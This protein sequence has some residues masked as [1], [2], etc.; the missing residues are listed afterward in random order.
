MDKLK[1][2]LIADD[3]PTNIKLLSD[4]LKREGYRIRVAVNG[5]QAVK[6]VEAELPDL[7]LMDVHMPK[8]NGYNAC[9][10][11]KA[12]KDGNMVP[13]IF[14]SAMAETFNKVLA[15]EAGAVDY[16]V[17]PFEMVEVL[18]RV[19]THISMYD[20]Q[21][22]LKD[23]NMDLFKKF[24]STFDQAAVGIVHAS[25]V[26]GKFLKVNGLFS[27]M[28]GY[29]QNEVMNM[30]IIDVLH[31]D[32]IE[33]EMS[34]IQGL[35]DN[36][37]SSYSHELLAKCKNQSY[38]WIRVTVSL[39]YD[40]LGKPDY[41]VGII[42]DISEQKLVEE[43]LKK[44]EKRLKEAQQ[45]AQLGN[46]E[47]DLK[48][49]QLYWSEE[50]F[51]IFEID[52]EKFEATYE[53][54]INIVHPDD[55]ERVNQ[56]YMNH[57]N[58]QQP[59][60]I[61]HRILLKDSTVKYVH[62]NGNIVF[63]EVGKAIISTGTVQDITEKKLAESEILKL[64]QELEERV[65]VRTRQLKQE[66]TFTDKVV[67][68]LPGIFYALDDE[69]RLKRWNDNYKNLVDIDA[70]KLEQI[71]LTETVAEADRENMESA[72]QNTFRD[73][74]AS[75][76]VCFMTQ[77]DQAVPYFITGSH[78]E[79]GDEDYYVGVGFDITK[80]KESEA[81]LRKLSRA[82]D[83]SP[84]SVVITDKDGRIQYVNKT[85]TEVTGYEIDDVLGKNPSVLQ[86]GITKR[87]V[88]AELWDTISE[89]L[90]WRGE[91]LNKK[92][93]G[94]IFWEAAS[95][96]PI[97]NEKGK[98]ISFVAVKED[99]TERKIMERELK[100]ARDKAESATVAKSEFLANM[101]HEIRTPMNAIIGM[102]HLA[103]KTKLSP[104]QRD[105]IT[106]ISIAGQNL[107]SIINEIL[108]FSKI[109]AGKLT[110]ENVEFD[111]NDVITNLSNIIVMKAQNK[112]LEVA[113][114]IDSTIGNHLIGDPLRLG[115][116]LLNLSNNAVKF[117]ESG[118]IIIR[119]E[120]IFNRYEIQRLKF[121]IVDTGIG[122]TAEQIGKLF[123]SFQQAD[124]S[125][126]RKYGGTGL[127]LVICKNIVEM[128]GGTIAVESEFHKGST[129]HF[130]I[131]FKIPIES[132][133]PEASGL[134]VPDILNKMPV[135]FDEI[136][137]ASILLVEDNE[138]NRQVAQEILEAEGFYINIAVNGQD[139]VDQMVHKQNHYD[140]ILMD[141]QMPVL[142]G[143]EATRII[144]EAMQIETVPIIAMTADAMAG[145]KKRIIEYGMND[146]VSKPFDVSNL[147]LTLIKWI[148][149]GKRVLPSTYANA[150]QEDVIEI[151]LPFVKLSG[152]DIKTGLVRT[153]SD[154]TLYLSLLRKFYQNNQ[155]TVED[156]K[157]A[158]QQQDYELA[159][160]IAHTTKSVAGLIGALRLNEISAKLE[161]E[162]S[163]HFGSTS[164]ELIV[165]FEECMIEILESLR[166]YSEIE[167]DVKT[168]SVIGTKE[169]LFKVLQELLPYSKSRSLTMSKK[170]IAELESKTW[171]ETYEE[172]V[173]GIV[174]NIKKYK[175]DIAKETI[176][177]I[178]NKMKSELNE[179][180]ESM[181]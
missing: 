32:Y 93:N 34:N 62:E 58:N 40:S 61:D 104:K 128:M 2:I 60:D 123:E 25:P 172:E 80:R 139:A 97:L 67:N 169:D 74:F 51:R 7:V 43:T 98:I 27:S 57:I 83:Q 88:Y 142:D 50:V 152:I 120:K 24:Q 145:T 13:V 81:E 161:R 159:G 125:T 54:F 31:P 56:A 176:E 77:S 150:I 29:S 11:I 103:L 106:K 143:Y 21:Q 165:Q 68:S 66:K 47:L 17:K 52:F 78:L 115:Q 65:G 110:L 166:L 45:L 138:I 5:E 108:D 14:V 170:Y 59:Y 179:S 35:L 162:I 30:K 26:D 136:R 49:N 175:F 144:R 71:K 86:S 180:D 149:P 72:I 73:G 9:R 155:K 37:Y 4:I 111:L 132:D 146:F 133:T 82:V 39:I 38:I 122:L 131:D 6:S 8:M 173:R 147:F 113:F 118:E 116:V 94:E 46:W 44:N 163:T 157:D 109:E 91:F 114:D 63:D 178:I 69:G 89:G 156:I 130:T 112:G 76:E 100:V 167:P 148:K 22:Q 19:K 140:V 105:F 36:I 53:A 102:S 158:M 85:F 117:T 64:N 23:I 129:F 41:M 20:Y 16:I 12:M 126:T 171:D 92:K 181:R 79:V 33:K 174:E 95:I 127:G 153:N 87:E 137:G 90:T 164:D 3:N 124:A 168:R 99:V 135:G 55:R 151:D 107:L 154:V 134:D 121:S 101:S 1:T 42:E 15:F 160:R 18:V 141:L 96:S 119:V 75:S 84:A 48:N 70:S 177:A 28:L 10:K